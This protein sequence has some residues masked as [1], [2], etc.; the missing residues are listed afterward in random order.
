MT[1]S[2]I[3]PGVA[4]ARTT[5][6][7][8]VAALVL[9]LVLA[10]CGGGQADPVR[11]GGTPSGGGTPGD[12]ASGDTR[13]GDAVSG[14]GTSPGATVVS[15]LVV[16]AAASL[17]GVMD[18]LEALVE[19]RHP[20]I[21][22]QANLGG[23]QALAAQLEQGAPGGVFVSANPDQFER[24]EP[25]LVGPGDLLATNELVVVVPSANP[26]GITTLADLAD[27]GV[28]VALGAPGVPVGDYA[29]EVLTAA[30]LTPTVVTEE[31]DVRS[32]VA[33]VAAGEVDAGIAYAT[34][35]VGPLGDGVAAVAIPD[36]VNLV[37][38]VLIGI[39]AGDQAAAGARFVDVALGPD[40]QALLVEARFSPGITP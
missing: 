10:G 27:D 34:D 30:G 29:R 33:K 4:A 35:V 32:V 6:V 22:V 28:T 5:G 31:L 20:D 38:D 39:V 12:T 23:S 1:S 3:A 2:G 19:R 36:D 14:D 40:G 24:V 26:A 8:G 25:L 17:A 16:H 11:S 13:S 37:T 9:G 7:L 15:P 18:D 21:D